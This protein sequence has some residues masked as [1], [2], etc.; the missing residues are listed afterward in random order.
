LI[1][2]SVLISGLLLLTADEAL[3]RQF[4]MIILLAV[5]SSL[6]PYMFT[7]IS[8]LILRKRFDQKNVFQVVVSLVACAYVLW[9]IFSAGAELLYLGCMI[10][11]SCVPLYGIFL[12][13]RAA[14]TTETTVMPL[15]KV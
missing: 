6:V 15:E 10:F 7:S 2:T 12:A 14:A 11:F 9:A 13:R 1:F 4:E 5:L 3:V 8:L